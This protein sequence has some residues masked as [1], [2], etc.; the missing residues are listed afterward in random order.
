MAFTVF[1][2]VCY[3]M[4]CREFRKQSCH[5]ETDRERLLLAYQ[6]NS[7]LVAGRFPVSKEMAA[8]L[9]SLM[10][11]VSAEECPQTNR[12]IVTHILVLYVYVVLSPR[13]PN[14]KFK[15]WTLRPT[16][17]LTRLHE[18]SFNVHYSRACILP[19]DVTKHT[20]AI[21]GRMHPKE[22]AW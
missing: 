18:V 10:A 22:A 15:L 9:A 16:L 6:V 3:L 20:R 8:E 2:I 12:K 14:G 19:M 13:S 1:K 7:D 11:Q 17:P 5:D 21:T 4:S